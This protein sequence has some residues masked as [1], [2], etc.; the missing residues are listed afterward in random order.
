MAYAWIVSALKGAMQRC[1]ERCLERRFERQLERC[2]KRCQFEVQAF[3]HLY[4]LAAE[5]RSIE[6]IDVDSRASVFVPLT[7]T[8]A[9]STQV[10]SIDT[11]IVTITI[12]TLSTPNF[13]CCP[14]SQDDL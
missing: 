1:L 14:S 11:R 4:V 5:S 3:R 8:L 9:P 2:H 13:D 10:R 7:V 6:A 12:P